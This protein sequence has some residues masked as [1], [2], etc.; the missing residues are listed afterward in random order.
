MFRLGVSLDELAWRMDVSR[1][2]LSK[3]LNHSKT[4]AQCR[5]K[6]ERALLTCAEQ[7][8]IT[9]ADLASPDGLTAYELG[10]YAC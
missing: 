7:R 10:G 6:V 2:Y 1:T 3:T 9:A 8:G 4:T 5:A